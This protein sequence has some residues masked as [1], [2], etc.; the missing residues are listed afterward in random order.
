MSGGKNENENK[1]SCGEIGRMIEKFVKLDTKNR[2]IRDV[3]ALQNS[4]DA[5]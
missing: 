4:L 5:L 2:L 3:A 1:F